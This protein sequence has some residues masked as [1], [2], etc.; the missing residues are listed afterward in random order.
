VRIYL[1]YTQADLDHAK[2][3]QGILQ[4]AG[5]KVF[6]DKE[7]IPGGEEW[8]RSIERELGNSDAVVLIWSRNAARSGWV[9][10]E[11]SM[12]YL[13]AK[14]IVQ[15]TLDTQPLNP[16]IE[17]L[18]ALSWGDD[19]SLFKSRLLESLGISPV[20]DERGKA[21]ASVP[22]AIEKYKQFIGLQFGCL[23]VLGRSEVC[24]IDSIYLPLNIRQEALDDGQ[25]EPIPVTQ[26]LTLPVLQS[27]VLGHPGTGKSTALKYLVHRAL[28]MQNIFPIYLRIAE[29]MNTD[30]SLEDFITE[31]M[32][33]QIGKQACELIAEDERYCRAGTL[34]LL[35]GLDEITEDEKRQFVKHLAGF[36]K[37]HPD[38]KLII[39]SRFAGYSPET[40][41]GFVTYYLEPLSPSNIEEYVKAVCPVEL[42]DNAWSLIKGNSRLFE[43]AKTPFLLAMMCASPSA[44]GAGATQRAELFREC[45]KYLLK[46]KDYEPSGPGREAAPE[47]VAHFLESAMKTIAV[48]LFKLDI[49]DEFSEDE[50]LFS[51]RELAQKNGI[52]ARELVEKLISAT[53][54]LH[55]SGKK[56]CFVHRTIWEYFV[57]LGMQD[58]SIDNLL[59]RASVPAW[60]EPIRLYV[61]LTPPEGVPSLITGLWGKNKGLT[62][63][64]LTELTDIPRSLL[65]QLVGGLE[66]ADRVR[67]MYELE[68]T[69]RVIRNPLDAKR[70]LLDTVRVTLSF[71]KD[72]EVLYHCLYML[73]GMAKDQ[74][75]H[76]CQLLVDAI[77]ETKSID[78]RRSKYLS[79]S[80]F[81]CE[82][83]SVPAGEFTMGTDDK[84]RTPDEKPAHTVRLDGFSIMRYPVTNELYY[85][86][87][88]YAVDRRESRSDKDHQ[89]VIY[90]TWYEAYL[91]ARW[92]GWDL[93][94]EAEWEFACRSGGRDDAEL[95]DFAKIPDYAWFA[96]NSGNLTHEVGLKKANSLGLF[97]MLG[98]VREW[99]KDWFA[100]GYYEACA[101]TGIVTNP[102]GPAR[103][104][105]K[106]IR[107]GGFDWNVANLV[108]TYRPTNTPDSSYF[109]NGFR[110]VSR[111]RTP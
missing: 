23:T 55:R 24:P 37:G 53:G 97:D 42:R 58:E 38:C 108:P 27:V 18:Q 96:E 56:L 32:K 20:D 61:G 10:R 72:C 15:C 30:E 73:E 107:G 3:T 17:H 47:E 26:L 65:A 84:G 76:E 93:P 8:E 14:K 19:L 79:D 35:D 101:K 59:E 67:L 51:V 109:V 22:E 60:E 2:T 40:L 44:L 54:L 49:K 63:R 43:L 94:T 90:P 6:F 102:V 33:G 103:G 28:N 68:E 100:D 77:L 16:L 71:E 95:Y 80:S 39:T 98:N 74:D 12:A 4:D 104:K 45:I 64:S 83:V 31:Q 1:C 87:F 86:A 5:C 85:D 81:R 88:P 9:L 46:E 11:L 66:S 105:R 7:T 89:P 78:A 70:T 29:L 99:C 21:P 25:R 106:I 41:P 34:L 82:F 48:R 62:L 69:L 92:L 75:C 91:F 57:A 36:R 111:E 50:I 110:L 52:G 13:K